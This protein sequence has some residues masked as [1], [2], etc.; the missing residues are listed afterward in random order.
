MRIGDQNEDGG[1][2]R[3]LA[4]AIGVLSPGRRQPRVPATPETSDLSR[5]AIFD[6]LSSTR[7]RHLIDALRDAGGETDLATLSREV[8]ARENGIEADAVTSTLRRRA[9]TA[10][11]QSHLP[12]LDREGVVRFDAARGAVALTEEFEVLAFYLDITP[13]HIRRWAWY[14]L[15]LGAFSGTVVGGAM[16]G[17]APFAWIPETAW[18]V[19]GGVMLLAIAVAHLLNHERVQQQPPEE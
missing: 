9:Y 16:S 11:R 12:K 5:E 2:L 8:A 17:L 1:G 13:H 14:Y 3:R 10:L 18:M 6:V 19:A 15:G 7:R 4:T